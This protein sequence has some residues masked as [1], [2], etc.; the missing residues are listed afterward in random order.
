M[1]SKM[2]KE[3]SAGASL[4]SPETTDTPGDIPAS[5]ILKNKT[6]TKQQVDSSGGSIRSVSF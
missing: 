3:L 5:W 6:K 4:L 1:S 2:K